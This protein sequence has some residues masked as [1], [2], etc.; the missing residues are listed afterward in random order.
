MDRQRRTDFHTDD[1][2][3]ADFER[4]YSRGVRLLLLDLD[5]TLE[6]PRSKYP[7]ERSKAV[8]E[9]AE[10]AGL[11]LGV[12][13]NSVHADRTLEF[14]SFLGAEVVVTRAQKPLPWKLR[15]AVQASGFQPGEICLAG[16]QLLTDRPAAKWSKILFMLV[17][18]VTPRDQ[19]QT[20]VN[21]F[22]ERP[23]R[24]RWR[25]KGLLGEKI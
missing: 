25:R 6:D 5:N 16:D 2:V 15:E 1:L 20:R 8:R 18:P 3:T 10:A 9:R 4:L 11:K 22:I 12:V 19:V 21:R 7:T 13:S 17:E 24:K 14:A 23:F